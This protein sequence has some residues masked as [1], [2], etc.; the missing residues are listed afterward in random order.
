MGKLVETLLWAGPAHYAGYL[1]RPALE[2]SNRRAWLH[3]DLAPL[4][5]IPSN[6]LHLTPLAVNQCKSSNAAGYAT[7][8]MCP[9][10]ILRDAFLRCCTIEMQNVML[11]AGFSV[12]A[13]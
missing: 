9:W 2:L 10:E 3:D 13:G 12:E 1:V 8:A 7:L 11:H 5:L 4:S 6:T